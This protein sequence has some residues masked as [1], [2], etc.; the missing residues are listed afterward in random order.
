[1]PKHRRVP[2]GG[3]GFKP[4][5]KSYDGI[6]QGFEGKLSNC[7]RRL[8]LHN[9]YDFG[10]GALMQTLMRTPP[11][12]DFICADPTPPTLKLPLGFRLMLALCLSIAVSELLKLK[13]GYFLKYFILLRRDSQT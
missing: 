1:M 8:C 12:E 7:L 9:N 2:V 3:E 11:Y 13:F 6:H 10:L 5:R 4:T